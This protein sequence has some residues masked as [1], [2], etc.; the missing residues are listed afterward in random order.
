MTGTLSV[1]NT[2]TSSPPRPELAFGLAGDPDPVVP[3]LFT[4]A[5][6]PGRPGG[7]QSLLG[8]ARG[9]LHVREGADH[10]DLLPVR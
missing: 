3:G 6:D 5:L 9:K 4:E 7:G 8:S 1:V 2:L 10:E